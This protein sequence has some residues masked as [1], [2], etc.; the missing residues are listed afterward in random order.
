MHLTNPE[1]DPCEIAD[2]D[3]SCFWK[4]NGADVLVKSQGPAQQTED[5]VGADD[6]T[7]TL[8]KASDNSKSLRSRPVFGSANYNLNS[9]NNGNSKYDFSSL[10]ASL[11]QF[12]RNKNK[13]LIAND[14]SIKQE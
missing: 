5:K 1:Q 7:P 13:K 3:D 14:T 2:D 12:L 9:N 6:E 11:Q 4:M 10:Y 8:E